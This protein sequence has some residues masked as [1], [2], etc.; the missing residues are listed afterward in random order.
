[1]SRGDDHASADGSASAMEPLSWPGGPSLTEADAERLVAG[2]S[3]HREAPAVQHALA[4]L[5][6]YAAG[7]ACDSELAGEIAAVA[8]FV[9]VNAERGTRAARS[10]APVLHVAAACAA[11]AVIA[12]CSGAVADILPAPIQEMAHTTFGA[13]APHAVLAR[14]VTHIGGHPGRANG[15]SPGKQHGGAKVPVGKAKPNAKPTAKATA[16]A[17]PKVTPPGQAKDHT[18]PPG[19]GRTPTPPPSA[20]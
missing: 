2:Y 3:P 18:A 9:L 17:K 10:R 13:P 4:D 6:D 15:L 5:L 8:A 7:P 20:P 11:A 19:H 12:T 14:R 1:M 16:R